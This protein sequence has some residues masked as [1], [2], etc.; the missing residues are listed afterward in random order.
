MLLLNAADPAA[1]RHALPAL[2]DLPTAGMPLAADPASLP[3]LGWQAP[4]ARHA[5][6]A[7]LAAPAWLR[8][9]GGCGLDVMFPVFTHGWN[10]ATAGRGGGLNARCTARHPPQSTCTAPTLSTHGHCPPSCADLYRSCLHQ[11]GPLSFFVAA[12]SHPGSAV[13]AP[14]ARRHRPGLDHRCRRRGLCPP[15]A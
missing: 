8:V 11:I 4:A 5:L 10:S 1:L 2:A 13:R 12:G 3:P 9:G 15:T 7:L 14:A 6:A